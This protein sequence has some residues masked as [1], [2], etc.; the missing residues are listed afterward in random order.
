MKSGFEASLSVL[1]AHNVGSKVIV[2]LGC[3]QVFD[4]A[5]M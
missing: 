1:G 5:N 2:Q 4:R 3:R